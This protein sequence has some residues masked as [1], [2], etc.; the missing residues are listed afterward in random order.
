VKAERLDG[1]TLP[2]GFWFTDLLKFGVL[3]SKACDGS[4]QEIAEKQ[5]WLRQWGYVMFLKILFAI[6]RK[7]FAAL[8]LFRGKMGGP[9]HI[10]FPSPSCWLISGC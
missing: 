9:S 7:L 5:A 10:T 6:L 8:Q 3:G 1:E 2:E 4:E